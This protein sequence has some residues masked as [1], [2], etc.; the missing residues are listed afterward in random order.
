MRTLLKAIFVGQWF[1]PEQFG[2][3]FCALFPPSL[4]FRGSGLHHPVREKL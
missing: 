1:T 2:C 3:W 4:L